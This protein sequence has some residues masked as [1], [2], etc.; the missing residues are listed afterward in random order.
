MIII[1]DGGSTKTNWCLLTEDGKKVYFNTEGYNPYFSSKEYIIK[2]LN[3][4][5]PTDLEKDK[6]TEVN[7]YGAGCSTE[8]KR[9]QV[10]EAMSAVFTK[11]KV[12]MTCLLRPGLC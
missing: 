9:K 6:I 2:S 8:E 12:N 3:E 5:L 10:E 7:Y 4:S 11:A 1:A